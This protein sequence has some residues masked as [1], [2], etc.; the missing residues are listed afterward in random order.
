MRGIGNII[1]YS[2]VTRQVLEETLK[3]VLYVPDLAKNLISISQMMDLNIAVVFLK[4][5]CKT[6]SHSG[7]GRLIFIG[8]RENSLWRLNIQSKPLS[9]SARTLT[10]SIAILPISSPILNRSIHL[11]RRL[12][13]RLGH[14]NVATIL[15]MVRD[16]A[17]IG[18]SIPSNAKLDF[19]SSCVKG[20][21]HRLPFLVNKERRRASLPG[22]F[23]HSDISG[24]IQVSILGGHRYFVTFKDDH[25]GYRIAF[26][27]KK[28]NEVFACITPLSPHQTSY[29]STPSQVS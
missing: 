15:K 19:Y 14:A 23:F 1:V 6:I 25:S 17:V 12:H 24:P 16:E 21:Q 29:N 20:K 8:R 10:S 4:D 2:F 7:K 5:A 18:L 9:S 22:V 11:L 26:L 3:N 28:N 27:M 13:N